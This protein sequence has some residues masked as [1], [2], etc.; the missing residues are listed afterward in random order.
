M[1]C[2]DKRLSVSTSLPC[3]K[4]RQN[5]AVSMPLMLRPSP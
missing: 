2:L 5:F 4:R 1:P 3:G